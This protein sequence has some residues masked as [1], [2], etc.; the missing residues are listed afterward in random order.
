MKKK[1]I[2][3]VLAMLFL[4]P[5]ISM[6]VD[7]S[8]SWLPNQEDD[9]AGYYVL[10]RHAFEEYDSSKEVWRGEGTIVEG[11]VRCTVYGLGNGI[12]YAVGL[13][14]N[15]SGLSSDYSQEARF[16]IYDGEF[17]YGD[18]SYQ[19]EVDGI[20]F[21]LPDADEID[22]AGYIISSSMGGVTESIDI[23]KATD[24]FLELEDGIYTFDVIPYND[25]GDEYPTYVLAWN[26]FWPLMDMPDIRVSCM[27][28]GST[29]VLA[30]IDSSDDS[31]VER[32]DY[33]LYSTMAKAESGD[34]D[35]GEGSSYSGNIIHDVS[36]VDYDMVFM[37]IVPVNEE[38]EVIG[39]PEMPYILFGDIIGTW[40]DGVPWYEASV[41]SADLN[42]FGYYFYS[43]ELVPRPSL[44]EYEGGNLYELLVLNI[45]GR[46]DFNHNGITRFDT[47]DYSFLGGK[48]F[49]EGID[50]AE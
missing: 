28:V 13:A 26:Y 19:V 31:R 10:I 36:S 12:Y 14:Y 50:Y 23:G 41:Y 45:Q 16:E 20:E 5:T 47:Q 2:V 24:Y 15:T 17:V 42:A 32:Y 44:E 3:L 40:N 27:G 29:K 30:G 9:L 7:Q 48:Y 8:F 25:Y 43:P 21:S 33:Y 6:A 49:N 34:A 39:S 35:I 11:R 4:L 18:V 38:Y 46:C 22:V 37:T 1:I